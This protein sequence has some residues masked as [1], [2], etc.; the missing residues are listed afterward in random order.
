MKKT[1]KQSRKENCI[2]NSVR[3]LYD[4]NTAFCVLA[5]ILFI[6]FL[7][8]LFLFGSVIANKSMEEFVQ[9]APQI[10]SLKQSVMSQSDTGFEKQELQEMKDI[11]DRMARNILLIITFIALLIILATGT[12]KGFIW[13]R[14][15]RQ[16]FSLRFFAKFLLVN[17][18][19]LGF[20][21]IACSF[22]LLK[23]SVPK[24]V[25]ILIV[26]SILVPYLTLLLY[27]SFSP[28]NGIIAVFQRSATFVFR[29]N[30]LNYL[31]MLLV[32]IVF[33]NIVMFAIGNSSMIFTT[34]SLLLFLIALHWSRIYFFSSIR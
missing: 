6:V 14:V 18:I 15:T 16:R 13:S 2:I 4:K 9:V 32:F 29:K 8:F 25:Y 26:L 3:A 12:I 22:V 24:N 33:S 28:K 1:K 27:S 11:V 23:I 5:D 17:L 21:F 7:I 31:Q 10:F 20:W 34:I 30:I 19:W